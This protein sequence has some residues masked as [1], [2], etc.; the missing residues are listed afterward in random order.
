[1]VARRLFAAIGGTVAALM[2]ALPVSA[3]PLMSGTGT[4]TITSLVITSNREAGGNRIQ[5]RV[6]AGTVTGTLEGTFVEEVQGVIHP[7][8][9]VTFQG[10]FTFTG[11]VENCGSGTFTLGL[12]GQG[13]AGAPVTEARVRVIGGEPNPLGIRGQGT[14]SQVGPSLT[15]D[16]QYKC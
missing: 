2:L 11:T 13:I 12:S 1:M 9:R 14:V 10:T 5:E 8:G 15:Y 3:S 7:N 4:G 6:L 16:V